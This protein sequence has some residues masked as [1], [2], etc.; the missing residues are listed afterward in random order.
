MVLRLNPHPSHQPTA[1]RMGQPENQS[2]IQNQLQNQPQSK[3]QK[4]SPN[5]LQEQLQK[6]IQKKDHRQQ[7]APKVENTFK[8]KFKGRSTGKI[9]YATN[10]SAKGDYGMSLPS[11]ASRTQKRWEDLSRSSARWSS[12]AGSRSPSSARWKVPKWMAM[13][14]AAPTS[15]WA[16]TA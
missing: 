13:V 9:A 12:V 1:R 8:R 6:Q 15:L 14:V 11:P 4:Q 5:Q 16:R 7:C 3:I 2:Q 10:A